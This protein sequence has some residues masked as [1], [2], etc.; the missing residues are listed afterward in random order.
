MILRRYKK[1]SLWFEGILGSLVFAAFPFASLCIMLAF[2]EA[3]FVAWCKKN[4]IRI[5]EKKSI[6]YGMQLKLAFGTEKA[7]VGLYTSGK[8]LVQGKEGLLKSKLNAYFGKTDTPKKSKPVVENADLNHN[9]K[10]WIGVDE[11]G[12]GDFFGPLVAC[13]VVIHKDVEDKLLS[14]GVKD[15]KKLSDPKV[16]EM[17]PQLMAKLKHHSICLMPE[18]YNQKYSEL[19]NLN[20]MLA[21]MHR[22]CAMALND[23]HVELVISDQFASD[24]TFLENYFVTA[25]LP[26]NK[27]LQVPR[28]EEDIAVA[29]ASI[30]ARYHFIEAIKTMSH[31]FGTDFPKGAGV[32]VDEVAKDFAKSFG[33]KHMN[34]VAKTHFKTYE[35][36]LDDGSEE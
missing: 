35:R 25:G 8:S 7:S 2:M 31:N 23:D 11:S 32:G 1:N 36:L 33:L 17:A 29:C 16:R 5:T 20:K 3:A 15:S 24:K 6:P 12:K 28:A 13:A 34:Q 27:L 26:K 4:D 10:V 22:D 9:K 19:D 30:I 14:L 18:D 21:E